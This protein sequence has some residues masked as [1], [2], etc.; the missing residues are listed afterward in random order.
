MP[1]VISLGCPKCRSVHVEQLAVSAGCTTALLSD[2]KIWMLP[3]ALVTWFLQRITLLSPLQ[4]PETEI[5]ML[6]MKR[7]SSLEDEI[8]VNSLRQR[9]QV[10]EV[11]LKLGRRDSDVLDRAKELGVTIALLVNPHLSLA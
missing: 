2:V 8:L 3:A 11:A 4:Q 10:S 9:R 1:N 5:D 7:W 6:K